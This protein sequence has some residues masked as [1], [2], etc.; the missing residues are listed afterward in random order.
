MTKSTTILLVGHGSRNRD[1]NKET[2]HFAAQWRERHPDWRIEVCFI[3]HAEVL[4]D[5]GLDRAARDA[6]RV[7]VSP[8]S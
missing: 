2:L 6:R 4:L 3:E 8:S 1:G 7:L 5:D